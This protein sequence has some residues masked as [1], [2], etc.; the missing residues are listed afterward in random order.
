MGRCKF[1]NKEN[2]L[3]S[4]VLE[5]CRKCLLE[6]DW[7]KVKEHLV[8]VHARVRKAEGLPPSAPKALSDESIYH[9]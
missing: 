8:S 4:K 6:L 1:C 5:T 9:C 2:K 3:I 7:N